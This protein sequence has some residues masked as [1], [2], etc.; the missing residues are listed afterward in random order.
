MGL[1]DANG[2]L[3][4]IIQKFSPFIFLAIG[5]LYLSS[6]SFN[7]KP[8][9]DSAYYLILAKSIL[10]GDGFCYLGYPCLKIPFG[11]PLLISPVIW[12][13]RSSIGALNIYMLLFCGLAFCMVYL[14]FQKTFSS[15]YARFITILFG[16]SS[17]ML[18]YSGYIM[19]D[20][21]Y[22]AFSFLSLF[23]ILNYIE[24][25]A[26]ATGFGAVVFLLLCF[27][28]RTVGVALLVGVFFFMVLYHKHLL[29]SYRFA[30]LSSLILF[31]V[32]LWGVHN[33]SVVIDN[34]DPVWQLQEFITSKD[35][36][37]RYR[38]DDPT[39]RITGMGDIVKRGAQNIGYYAG[40]S[41]SLMSGMK[42][43]PKKENLKLL[44]LWFLGSFGL[45]A[46]LLL[47]GIIASL[48]ERRTILDFYF[49][50]YIGILFSWSAREPRY[51]LPVLPMLLH[52]FV[53]GIL[54]VVNNASEK[55]PRIKRHF[56]NLSFWSIAIFSIFYISLHGVQNVRN[57]KKQHAREYYSCRMQ[58]FFSAAEWLK[59]NTALNARVVSVLAPVAS[60]FSER[61]CISFPRVEDQWRIL[62]FLHKAQGE[63][64]L[65]NPSYGHEERYLLSVIKNYSELFESEAI[66]GE[67][68]VYSVKP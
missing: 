26:L 44:P 48:I 50:L 5:V 23:F 56:P 29:K 47:I 25:P 52:Y 62:Q 28:L 39:S 46:S 20:V 42:I 59:A 33:H 21:P 41:S 9:W 11:F 8:E 31:P 68:V 1:F 40:V 53:A 3:R 15:V 36:A 60:L 37:R 18:L 63:Y 35:E 16:L 38:F 6:L 66:H 19:I 61:Q 14:C 24:R 45:I 64:I 12:L 32:V 55:I 51:L 2:R 4:T 57:V 22:V 10:A 65:V 27:F 43:N 34:N 54:F 58:N 30:L 13:T 7:W 49:L 67:A 17:L